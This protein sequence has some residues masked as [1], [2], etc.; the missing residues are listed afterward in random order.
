MD[1]IR[2]HRDVWESGASYEPYVGRWSRV[3]AREFVPWLDVPAGRLRVTKI[4]ER[5]NISCVVNRT[6]SVRDP[7][8]NSCNIYTRINDRKIR[9]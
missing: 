2:G 6:C 3:V 5:N 7:H 1:P 9:K 8:F 4:G